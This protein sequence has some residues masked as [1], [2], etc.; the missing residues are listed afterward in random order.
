MY[1]FSVFIHRTI[2][3][4]SGA[5]SRLAWEKI[6]AMTFSRNGA[7]LHQIAANVSFAVGP[8]DGDALVCLGHNLQVC[9]SIEGWKKKP[10]N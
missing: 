1:F 4:C 6:F 8:L 5:V 7:V 2:Q 3:S 9:G 10:S